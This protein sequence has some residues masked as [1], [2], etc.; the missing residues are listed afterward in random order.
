MTHQMFFP[1]RTVEDGPIKTVFL[2]F[3]NRSS[4][5]AKVL[6]ADLRPKG[7]FC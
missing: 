3:T 4:G 6:S 2:I 7:T 1:L 5:D